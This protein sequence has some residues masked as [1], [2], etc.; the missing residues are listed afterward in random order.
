M[1][2]VNLKQEE[3]ILEKIMSITFGLI[4]IFD[5]YNKESGVRNV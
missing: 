1:L 4:L 3:H 2:D 5:A